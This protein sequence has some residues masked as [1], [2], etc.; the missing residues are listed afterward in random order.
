MAQS[1]QAKLDGTITEPNLFED[2]KSFDVRIKFEEFLNYGDWKF[3]LLEKGK[4]NFYKYEL[5]YLTNSIIINVYLNDIGTRGG[6]SPYEKSLQFTGELPILDKIDKS[7]EDKE[8]FIYLGIY[9]KY[10]SDDYIIC[11]W[12]PS[13]WS[14]TGKQFNT[15]IDIRTI[16]NAFLWGKAYDTGKNPKKVIAFKPEFLYDFFFNINNYFNLS[17][18][19]EQKVVSKSKKAENIIYFG[20]PGTGK[21][22]EADKKTGANI[23]GRK[24]FVEKT[25]FHPEYDY[26]SFVGGYKP[27]MVKKDGENKIEYKFVPQIFTNIYVKAWNDL[28]NHYFL[29]IEEINRGNCA[30]IFGDLFQLLDRDENGKSRY[31]TTATEDLKIYLEENLKGNGLDGIEGGKLRLPSNLSIVATMN[32]SDQSLF[33]MDSAFKR[34]WDWEY[35]PIEYDSEKSDSDFIITLTSGSEYKWLDFLKE[36]NQRI[37][38]ATHSQDKQIGNWFIN[39]KNTG[40]IIDEK[41]FVNKVIFYL[42]NDVFKDEDLTIFKDEN[43]EIIKDSKDITY[44]HFFTNNINSQLMEHIFANNL[45]LKKI[46][47]AVSSEPEEA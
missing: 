39:A 20:S 45:N 7:K 26:N 11:A 28:D 44:E 15:N 5:S 6:R 38:K 33:P 43:N 17:E 37:L 35:V 30:E 13:D 23:E 24:E 29:Q 4:G 31:E 25:T 32:T 47:D 27:V 40:N 16:A 1:Y 12:N 46:K 19:G 34:R 8:L 2:N 21:S 22:F 36:V 41:T 42:W 18:I 9:K 14:T 3:K 10:D